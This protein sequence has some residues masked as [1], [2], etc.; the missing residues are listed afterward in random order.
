MGK[1]SRESSSSSSD[2]DSSDPERR[3]PPKMHKKEKDKKRDKEKKRK[4]QQKREKKEK[5]REKKEKKEKKSKHKEKSDCGTQGCDDPAE[6]SRIHPDR[7]TDLQAWPGWQHVCRQVKSNWRKLWSYQ[8]SYPFSD[9]CDRN[10]RTV[11]SLASWCR[12]HCWTNK[13]VHKSRKGIS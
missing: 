10:K 11:R 4:K 7:L 13:S 2:S 3:K 1:R 5:K 6:V 12:W 8:R 9:Y